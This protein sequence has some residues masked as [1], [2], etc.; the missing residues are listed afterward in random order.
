[1][2][3]KIMIKIKNKKGF[4][5]IELLIVMAIFSFLIL[6]I[7]SSITNAYAYTVSVNTEAHLENQLQYVMGSMKKIIRVGA[8]TNLVNINSG[9][10]NP[11]PP[12][13]SSGGVTSSCA[14]SGSLLICNQRGYVIYALSKGIVNNTGTIDYQQYVN[15]TLPC[16][17]S[18]ISGTFTQLTNQSN[19][20]IRALNFYYYNSNLSGSSSGTGNVYIAPYVTIYIKGCTL[21]RFHGTGGKRV[22]M[23]LISSATLE[24]YSY[25]SA[26]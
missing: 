25:G 26:N 2:L 1:M 15:S 21:H 11:N 14:S 8:S 23:N 3:I 6:V 13:S 18:S 20:D 19:I 22:C 9:I 4:T 24:N 16:S 12:T 17:G 10:C 5:L 7:M